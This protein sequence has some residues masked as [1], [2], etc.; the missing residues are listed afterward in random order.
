MQTDQRSGALNNEIAYLS[1]EEAARLLRSRALS[2]VDLVEACLARVAAHD[3]RISAWLHVDSESALK[4][5]RAIASEAGDRWSRGPLVGIPIGIKDLLD[6]AGMPTTWNSRL[7]NPVIPDADAAVVDRLRSNGAILLG[8]LAAWECGVG[9]AS[10][11]LPWPPTRNPW[12][13]DRDPGGSSTGSAA[14]VAAGLCFGAIGSDTGGSIREPASWCG[15][16]GLKPTLGL[17]SAAGG[18]AASL[19]FDH[20]GPMARS[21]VDCAIMLDAMTCDGSVSANVAGGVEGLRIGLVDL[22][23]EERLE[24]DPEVAAALA[25]AAASLSHAGARL[26]NVRLPRLELFSAVVAVAAAAEG[27][28]LHRRSLAISSHLYGPLT[29]Q[30][31]LVGARVPT[32]DYLDA[33]AARQQLTETVADVFAGHDLLLMPTTRTPAPPL[34]GFDSHGGHPSLCRPWNVTG[35]PALSVPCGISCEGLP[36]AVQIIARPNEDAIALRAGHALETALGPRGRPS[37]TY[38]NKP[39]C[40]VPALDGADDEAAVD[41]LAQITLRAQVLL[42]GSAAI[43]KP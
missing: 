28:A 6:V 43:W 25:K 42:R 16:V 3:A 38:P 19:S 32:P 34:G 41:A 30:R 39:F 22:N 7:R 37:D 35:Y 23:H 36:L 9:G 26:D 18:L 20:V 11:T 12:A 8:K 21:S 29:R 40:D 4:A 15:I 27:F 10:F 14:A 13:L 1:I 5:A 17:V 33:L 2:S 31:L 24:V